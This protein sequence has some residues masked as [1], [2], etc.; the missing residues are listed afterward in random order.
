MRDIRKIGRNS[1][2][3]GGDVDLEKFAWKGVPREDMRAQLREL[4]EQQKRHSSV[5]LRGL[6]SANQGIVKRKFDAL[7]MLLNAGQIGLSRLSRI[8]ATGLFRAKI[9]DKGK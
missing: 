3:Y 6:N 4:Y 8:G 2:R 1:L 9:E 7:C 5:V